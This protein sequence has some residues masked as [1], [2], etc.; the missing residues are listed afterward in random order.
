MK[1]S[2]GTLLLLGLIGVLETLSPI[3]CRANPG[4]TT[5]T[6]LQ[7][8]TGG[9]VYRLGT[10]QWTVEVFVKPLR[11]APKGGPL[12]LT[13]AFENPNSS[14]APLVVEG[15]SLEPNSQ[16]FGVKLESPPIWGMRDRQ[17]YQVTVNVYAD[18]S[19]TKLLGTHKQVIVYHD[20]GVR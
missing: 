20:I 12:Y 2:P 7:T 8:T 6:Y 13:A 14:R 18:E 19:R 5:S 3:R 4:K 16:K 9:F 11:S 15:N 17:G 1:L 10:R